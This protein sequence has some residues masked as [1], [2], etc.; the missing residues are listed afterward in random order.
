M[1]SRAAT[2]QPGR[3]GTRQRD[4]QSPFG[5]FRSR[6]RL[7]RPAMIRF[8]DEYRDQYG[9]ELVC[10]TLREHREGGFITSR[11][12]R[13]AKTRGRCARSI[14][15]EQ[16]LP[17]IVQVWE[18]NYSVY[19]ALKLQHALKRA[20]WQLGRDQVA[21]LMK[22]AGISGVRRGRG[23]KPPCLAPVET[24]PRICSSAP[25]RLRLLTGYGWQRS[26]MRA[27]VAGLLTRPSSPMPSAAKSWAGQ[28]ARP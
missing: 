13:Y 4:S 27:P 1:S 12:Y 17:I 26:R 14:R 5:F 28:C 20:G 3:D 8:I 16:L 7:P 6:A 21:R 24:S 15:D 25:S 2:R 23:S 11:A 22:I 9:V 10:R 18:D 19:G